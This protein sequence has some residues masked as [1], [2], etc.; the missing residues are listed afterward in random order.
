[1]AGRWSVRCR[2][3]AASDSRVFGVWFDTY[4]DA[5]AEAAQV[6]RLV[7]DEGGSCTFEPRPESDRPLLTMEEALM[8][9]LQGGDVSD[10]D[11]MPDE[12]NLLAGGESPGYL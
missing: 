8:V 6:S 5:D 12:V 2:D 7:A 11:P 3:H 4:E 10:C 9:T 1:M